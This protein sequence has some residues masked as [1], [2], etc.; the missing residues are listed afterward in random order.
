[1]PRVY[2]DI[3]GGQLDSVY[4]SESVEVFVRYFPEGYANPDVIPLKLTTLTLGELGFDDEPHILVLGNLNDGFEFIGPFDSF[5]DAADADIDENRLS[6]V[7]TL[8][9][10]E[11]AG[12]PKNS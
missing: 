6:W 7:A 1:M 10:P 5:D 11:I 3:I 8:T 2:I 9:T 4:S 12:A